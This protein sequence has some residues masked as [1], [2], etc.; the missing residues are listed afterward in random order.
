MP[1]TS[2]SAEGKA[3]HQRRRRSAD[4][5]VLLI[6]KRKR[7]QRVGSQIRDGEAEQAADAREKNAFRQQLAHDAAA[8]RAKR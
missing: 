5:H 2:E 1:V 6:G 4:R 3:D 7:Q 8:L